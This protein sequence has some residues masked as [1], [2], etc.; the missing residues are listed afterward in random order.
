MAL[1]ILKKNELDANN[2]LENMRVLDEVY[3]S[4]FGES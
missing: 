2:R 3:F 4:D 1:N